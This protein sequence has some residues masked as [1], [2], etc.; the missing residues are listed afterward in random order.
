LVWNGTGFRASV[1]FTAVVLAAGGFLAFDA[2]R[3]LPLQHELSG[4]SLRA[5]QG[6]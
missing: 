5:R 6:I 3:P 4:D 1:I 2:F